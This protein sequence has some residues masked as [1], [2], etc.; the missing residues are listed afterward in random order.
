[1]N[2]EEYDRLRADSANKNPGN[3]E[4]FD[5]PLCLNRG[6]SHFV[7]PGGGLYTK[8]CSCMVRRRNLKYLEESGL[9]DMAK[10]YTFSAWETSGKWQ[11][12]LLE[13]G[14]AY[15]ASPS[16]WFY[17]AGRPGTGKTHLCTAICCEL[18]LERGFPALYVLWRDFS[19]EAKAIVNDSDAY[20]ALVEPLKRVPVLYLDDLF[21]SGSRPTA[22]DIN[23]AFELINA[24]YNDISKITII[25]S[26]HTL[27]D[28][29]KINEALGSRIYERAENNY[30]DLSKYA[31]YRLRRKDQ[32]T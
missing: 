25:S 8:E 30:F 26:E 2:S 7:R 29:L 16:G 17:L 18:M 4:G 3:E 24:R 14:K 13:K 12:S 6:F 5:C 19:V 20:K 1:M 9:A 11:S 31:N 15:A 22:G 10:R 32:G 28:L 27:S 21:K 23:L